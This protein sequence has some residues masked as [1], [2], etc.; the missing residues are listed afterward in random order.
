V[1]TEQNIS[2]SDDIHEAIGNVTH[3]FT[4]LEGPGIKQYIFLV[5][6]CILFHYVLFYFYGLFN[7]YTAMN[8]RTLMN[9]KLER[10]WKDVAMA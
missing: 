2:F 10:V 6:T 3:Y 1:R 9:N 4:L 8:D 5:I 7:N